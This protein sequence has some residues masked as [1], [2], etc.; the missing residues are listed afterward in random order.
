M[1]NDFLSNI[2]S[3]Y[4]AQCKLYNQMLDLSAKQVDLLLDNNED[5]INNLHDI[6]TE[7]K[8]IMEEITKLNETNK[9]MQANLISDLGINEFVISKLK[10]LVE[11]KTT[12]ELEEVIS[13]MSTLLNKINENDKLNEALLKQSARK[14]QDTKK[15]ISSAK[16]S[17]AYKEA[18]KKSE[19]NKPPN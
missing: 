11:K 1:E 5:T 6:I 18:M 17:N 2:I 8:V 12:Q 13:I 19:S 3:N 7:R 9:V 4:Q 10:G 15:S 14:K 16:V